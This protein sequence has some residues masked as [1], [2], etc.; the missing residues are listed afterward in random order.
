MM[1]DSDTGNRPALLPSADAMAEERR[2]T[3]QWDM[4]LHRGLTKLELTSNSTPP[5]DSA[6]EWANQ[7]HQAVQ[8]QAEQ[9]RSN[10]PTVRF[11]TEP[12]PSFANANAGLAA[13]AHHQQHHH[14][15]SAPSITTPREAKRHGWYHGPAVTVNNPQGHP[16]QPADPRAAYV[17]RMAHPN[18]N[19]FTG[20]PAR[21]TQPGNQPPAASNNPNPLRGLEALVAV[22]TSEGTAATAY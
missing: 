21:E 11:E 16:E 2:S 18:M 19:A 9:V 17:D 20:F 3:V 15:L 13:R 10:P 5:R 22:A 8:A 7:V 1:V 6:G 14:T 12:S 4:G